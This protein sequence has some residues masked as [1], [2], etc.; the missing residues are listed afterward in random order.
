M[1]NNQNMGKMHNLKHAL[2]LAFSIALNILLVNQF[3]NENYWQKNWTQNAAE[4]AEAVSAMSCSGHGRAFL[5]GLLLQG[6][7]ICECNTCYGGSDCSQLLPDCMVD[8]DRYY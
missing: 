4:E 7:P 3:M 8:A 5:D 1:E 6:N 2:C